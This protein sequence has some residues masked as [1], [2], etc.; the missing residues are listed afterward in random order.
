MRL[1]LSTRE[2]L[3]FVWLHFFLKKIPFFS[4][5]SFFR[6]VSLVRLNRCDYVFSINNHIS[7]NSANCYRVHSYQCI[8]QL[9]IENHVHILD[10]LYG[11]FFFSFS[12]CRLKFWFSIHGE[13]IRD[14]G[15]FENIQQLTEHF[16]MDHIQLR[17]QQFWSIVLS[18][19]QRMYR[20]Y[21][22]IHSAYM[23]TAFGAQSLH[24]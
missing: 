17:R 21:F 6:C 9:I 24:L 15:Q 10:I 20:S 5:V 16:L 3:F 12:F 2:P 1:I 22:G 11:S 23:Q 4:S 13:R 7:L 8:I 19:L 18:S 14:S